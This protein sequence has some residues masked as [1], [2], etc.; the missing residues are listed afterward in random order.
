MPK[1]QVK[2]ADNPGYGRRACRCRDKGKGAPLW[3]PKGTPPRNGEINIEQ[4]FSY[5]SQGLFPSA[6]ARIII[7]LDRWLKYSGLLPPGPPLDSCRFYR[8]YAHNQPSGKMSG[9]I[10]KVPLHH[11]VRWKISLI[12]KLIGVSV[13]R[14][15]GLFN[16]VIVSGSAPFSPV[17]LFILA[18]GKRFQK[19]IKFFLGFLAENPI[20]SGQF[21]DEDA[22]GFIQKFNRIF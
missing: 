22:F 18:W 2:A 3:Q 6:P 20:C 9:A 5:L 8:R 14:F 4:G 7:S 15:S 10:A 13:E 16:T 21:L 17:R 1:P 11:A 12:W 19:F